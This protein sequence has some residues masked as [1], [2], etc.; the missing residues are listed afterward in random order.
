MDEMRESYYAPLR[1]KIFIYPDAKEMVGLFIDLEKLTPEQ[2][3]SIEIQE[4]EKD[5]AFITKNPNELH[6]A[7]NRDSIDNDSIRATVAHEIGHL[8][9]KGILFFNDE[10]KADFFMRYYLDTHNVFNI[11]WNLIIEYQVS[12]LNEDVKD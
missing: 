12:K 8:Q 3:Q 4:D 9:K 11:V 6:L 2:I 10:R 7:F 1:L 5:Y